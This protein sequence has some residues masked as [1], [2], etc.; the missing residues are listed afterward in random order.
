M[1][2]SKQSIARGILDKRDLLSPEEFIAEVYFLTEDS[3]LV[4]QKPKPPQDK[5]EL[6]KA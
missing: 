3:R 5:K 1:A 6:K 2:T 4:V